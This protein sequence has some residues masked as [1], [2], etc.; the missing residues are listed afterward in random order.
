MSDTIS[1]IIMQKSIAIII[2]F[3]MPAIPPS[4]LLSFPIM[5]NEKIPFRNLASSFTK[6]ISIIMISS[7]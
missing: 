4:I 6:T 2:P 7:A 3:G 1:E 5:L